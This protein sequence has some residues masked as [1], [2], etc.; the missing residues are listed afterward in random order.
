MT[1]FLS[2][3]GLELECP[4][5]APP[6]GGAH[7]EVLPQT[8]PNPLQQRLFLYRFALLH[9]DPI[10]GLCPQF[11][12]LPG[13]QYLRGNRDLEQWDRL[14][15]GCYPFSE[16]GDTAVISPSLT[17][18]LRLRKYQ[19]LRPLILC[20]TAF[21]PVKAKGYMNKLVR[22]C[23]PI[24]WL[25]NDATN[26]IYWLS[27]RGQSSVDRVQAYVGRSR[28]PLEVLARLLREYLPESLII[29]REDGLI[30]EQGNLFVSRPPLC[31]PDHLARS[32]LK[33]EITFRDQFQQQSGACYL[34]SARSDRLDWFRRDCT[35]LLDAR[36]FCWNYPEQPDPRDPL[37]HFIL[38]P[39]AAI[40]F[41]SLGPLLPALHLDGTEKQ[42]HYRAV[43]R[44]PGG[45]PRW[46]ELERVDAFARFPSKQGSMLFYFR[47]N[48]WFCQG[49]PSDVVEDRSQEFRE[50]LEALNLLN[51]KGL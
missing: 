29:T 46:M 9:I 36:V 7:K 28:H 10:V 35:R 11:L 38:V 6:N 16:L 26:P 50:R 43:R 25:L 34:F 24:T 12:A 40:R 37:V 39:D 51:T 41:A 20:R 22:R 5:L 47:D 30:L 19:P 23:H 31:T 32:R 48:S 14:L 33:H 13:L 1:K 8:N 45:R 4:S 3:G 15:Q 42:L 21:E 27:P 17:S 18:L 49:G 2:Q 44:S